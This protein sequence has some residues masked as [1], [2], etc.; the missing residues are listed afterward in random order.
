MHFRRSTRLTPDPAKAAELYRRLRELDRVECHGY[1][2][3]EGARV[4]L[5]LSAEAL[6]EPRKVLQGMRPPPGVPVYHDASLPFSQ[7]VTRKERRRRRWQIIKAKRNDAAQGYQW[8]GPETY[9]ASG[10]QRFDFA[11]PYTRTDPKPI[12]PRMY[13]PAPQPDRR[14]YYV[15][16]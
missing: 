3:R 4:E 5:R 9:P 11:D 14:G 13:L 12:D 2:H 6:A 10:L 1:F 7:Y 16:D 15:S 8:P